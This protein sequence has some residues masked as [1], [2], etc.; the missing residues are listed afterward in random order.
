MEPLDGGRAEKGVGLQRAGRRP[1]AIFRIERKYQVA[2]GHIVGADRSHGIQTAA[3]NRQRI[4]RN[5][6][7]EIGFYIQHGVVRAAR[8][9]H[10]NRFGLGELQRR[11][12][13]RHEYRAFEFDGAAV[14]FDVALRKLVHVQ[15]H[16]GAAFGANNEDHRRMG[17]RTGH[18][19]TVID[20][21]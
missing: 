4:C 16:R 14:G 9:L 11:R 6:H 1:A 2:H 12:R 13:S 21:G 8:R 17:H 3:R 5:G 7:R 15:R 19:G 10:G 18:G 20:I